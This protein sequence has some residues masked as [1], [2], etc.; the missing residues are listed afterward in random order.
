MK[1]IILLLVLTL[2]GCASYGNKIDRNYASNIQKGVTTESDVIANLGKPASTTLN[3]QGDRVLTYFHSKTTVH[4]STFVP[5]V[6]A[7]MAGADTEMTTLTVSID[8]ESG[9]VEDWSYSE[10]NTE[11]NQGVTAN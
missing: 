1:F 4:A 6:G 5:I 11:A 3:A 2:G 10:T 9:I 8:T 7:F